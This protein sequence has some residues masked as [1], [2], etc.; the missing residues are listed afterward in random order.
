M[1]HTTILSRCTI[2]KEEHCLNLNIACLIPSHYMQS[3]YSL[4]NEFAYSLLMFGHPQ[5]TNGLQM[6][7]GNI[8]CRP[9]IS[10]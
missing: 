8:Y 9:S 4:E 1:F 5:M 6:Y 7:L 3:G 10:I 2:H